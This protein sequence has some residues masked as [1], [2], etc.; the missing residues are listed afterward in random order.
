MTAAQEAYSKAGNAL[1]VTGFRPVQASQMSGDARIIVSLLADE[2]G[3][4]GDDG[5]A[6]IN[7]WE[8]EGDRP[9]LNAA[10]SKVLADKAIDEAGILALATGNTSPEFLQA[11]IDATKAAIAK[12]K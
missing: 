2:N 10:M 1:P 12:A 8:G 6:R 4:I 9:S 3:T 11:F 7:G 5:Y